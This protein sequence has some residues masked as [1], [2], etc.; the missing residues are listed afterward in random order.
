MYAARLD[1]LSQLKV[2]EAQEGDL[3]RS[4]L[5]LI[6]PA[7]NLP[8][9][10]GAPADRICAVSVSGQAAAGVTGDIVVADG[11][12]DGRFFVNIATYALTR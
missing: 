9:S 10:C 3:F 6:A 5:V 7:E 11:D 2:M 4:G 8:V 1:A 12:A